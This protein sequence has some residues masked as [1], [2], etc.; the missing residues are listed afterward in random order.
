MVKSNE[1]QIHQ[2]TPLMTKRERERERLTSK[3]NRKQ[4][5]PLSFE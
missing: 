2:K 1:K 3:Y 5:Q 4:Q